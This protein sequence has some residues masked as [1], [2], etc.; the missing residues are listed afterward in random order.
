MCGRFV[1]KASNK[2]LKETFEALPEQLN[3]DSRENELENPIL[4]DRYNG[5]LAK[6]A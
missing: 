2:Q 4:T 5:P 6:V 1:L 3:V